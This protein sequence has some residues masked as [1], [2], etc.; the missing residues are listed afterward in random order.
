MASEVSSSAS[1]IN[2]EKEIAY[3]VY[4]LLATFTQL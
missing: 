4:I 3:Y 1:G 2:E